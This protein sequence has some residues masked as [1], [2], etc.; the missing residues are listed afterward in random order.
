MRVGRFDGTHDEHHRAVIRHARDAARELARKRISTSLQ[1]AAAAAAVPFGGQL[2]CRSL[3]VDAA[4]RCARHAPQR[5]SGS[6]M[7][8]SSLKDA[9][10]KVLSNM[11]VSLPGVHV[12]PVCPMCITQAIRAQ[13]P[14][15]H[16]RPIASWQPRRAAARHLERD[17]TALRSTLPVSTSTLTAGSA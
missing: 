8:Q 10:Q 15:R 5:T 11:A 14:A 6:T 12:C 4:A 17:R 7:A 16:P 3:A 1:R 9:M 2:E 13:T